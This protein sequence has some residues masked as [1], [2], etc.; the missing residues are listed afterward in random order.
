MISLKNVCKTYFMG[1]EEIHALNNVTLN[2]QKGEFI[3]IVGPSGSRK[4]YTYEYTRTF[5]CAR[6]RRVFAK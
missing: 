6:Q 5:R 2:I 1:E 4:V 3:A